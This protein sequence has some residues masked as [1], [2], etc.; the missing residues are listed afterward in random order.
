[1]VADSIGHE[2]QEVWLAVLEDIFPSLPSR[3][4]TG[5]SVIPIHSAT[6]NS[7]GNGP[8]DDTI[9]C[10]LIGHGSRDG[11][12]VVPEKEE[13]LAAESGCEIESSGE[14]ALTGCSLAEVACGHSGLLGSSES[15]A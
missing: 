10:V 6:G 9:R 1:M 7:E 4:E 8:G 13:G 15:V 5:H 14:V 2:L 12:F 3:L 11:V